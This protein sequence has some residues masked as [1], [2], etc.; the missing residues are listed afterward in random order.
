ME[1]WTWRVSEPTGI[2]E[3]AR[4]AEAE[5]WDGIGLGDSQSLTGGPV[6]L[7][8]ARGHRHGH[9][10]TRDIG[11]QS[12]DPPRLGDRHFGVC[13]AVPVPRPQWWTASP[14]R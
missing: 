2:V 7:P 6:C 13:V 11:D 1:F 5:G 3:F 12:R 8:R 10:G 4:R 9:A 14:R